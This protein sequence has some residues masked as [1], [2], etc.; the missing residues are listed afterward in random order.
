MPASD[1]NSYVSDEQESSS[2]S[3]DPDMGLNELFILISVPISTAGVS[4]EDLIR[5]RFL[6]LFPCR[7][8]TDFSLVQRHAPGPARP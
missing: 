1:N 7:L 8:S 2:G 3:S 5:V 6:L 4:K